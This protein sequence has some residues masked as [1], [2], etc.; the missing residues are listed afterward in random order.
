MMEPMSAKIKSSK[1]QAAKLISLSLG[2]L[3]LGCAVP[4]VASLNHSGT[5]KSYLIL[6][7]ALG[8]AVLIYVFGFYL[9]TK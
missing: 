7:E 8:S 1:N 2:G 6:M 3:I 5:A 9:S 4:L